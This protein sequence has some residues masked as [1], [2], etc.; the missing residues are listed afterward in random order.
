MTER[1]VRVRGKAAHVP[2]LRP[3]TFGTEPAGVLFPP[4]TGG[5]VKVTSPERD[6]AGTYL[7]FR[8]PPTTESAGRRLVLPPGNRATELRTYRTTDWLIGNIGTVAGSPT[9]DL[10]L[11]VHNP[12][13]LEEVSRRRLLDDPASRF[14]HALAGALMGASAGLVWGSRIGDPWLGLV[15]GLIIGFLSGLFAPTDWGELLSMFFG[16]TDVSLMFALA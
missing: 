12:E 16:A 8:A 5:L 7:G 2:A 15:V 3:E 9:K 1:L 4:G 11:E 13:V 10:Q 6:G 14:Y